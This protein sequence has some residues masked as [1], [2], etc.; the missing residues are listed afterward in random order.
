MSRMSRIRQHERVV[1]LCMALSFALSADYMNLFVRVHAFHVPL[2]LVTVPTVARNCHHNRCSCVGRTST[3]S[4]RQLQWRTTR[5]PSSTISAV[6]PS[7]ITRT[8][9]TRL[10]QTVPPSDDDNL[11]SSSPGNN[12]KNENGHGQHDPRSNDTADVNNAND[13]NNDSSLSSSFTF[14]L[15][16]TT[17]RRSA[18]QNTNTTVVPSYR[19]LLRFISTTILIWLS[20]PLL[21]LVDTTLVGTVTQQSSSSVHVPALIQLA[22]LGPATML[23]DSLVYL[24]YFLSIATTCQ[25]ARLLAKRDYQQMRE[26]TSEILGIS[27][28]LGAGITLLMFSNSSSALLQWC[29]GSAGRSTPLLLQQALQY[30][31]IRC[32][33]SIF[34]IIG[35]QAQSICLAVQDTRTPAIAMAVAS[36][37]NVVGDVLLIPRHGL[38]GAALA[39]AA[40]SVLSTCVLLMSIRSKTQEWKYYAGTGTRTTPINGASVNGASNATTL[41]GPTALPPSTA[42]VDGKPVL[43][44]SNITLN[45]GA[46]RSAAGG[47]KR[48]LSLSLSSSIAALRKGQIPSLM[49]LTASPNNADKN[50]VPFLSLPNKQSAI[51]LIQLAGPLFFIIVAKVLSYS[52]L[53]YK[54]TN[55]GVVSVACHS[56]MMRIFFFYATFG[57]ALTQAAQTYLPSTLL[58]AEATTTTGTTTIAAEATTTTPAQAAATA[59]VGTNEA[60]NDNVNAKR[61]LSKLFVFATGIGLFNFVSIQ[62][63][64]RRMGR[65]FTQN[66]E[67]IAVMTKHSF[68]ISVAAMLHSFIMVYEG[69]LIAKGD[70]MFLVVSYVT[71]MGILVTQLACATPSFAQVWSALLVFQVLRLAQFSVR[72][73]HTLWLRRR[74]QRSDPAELEPKL[75]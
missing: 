10:H 34:T 27:T 50:D 46:R 17:T 21:S 57:D 74:Q 12:K 75:V 66:T 8:C 65:L 47:A 71:I 20:E 31:R 35:I 23:I 36:V 22:A 28:L 26:T 5:T 19:A 38:Q 33:V 40:A 25:M 13:N 72:V 49:L 52:A 61:L 2:S 67:I 3:V 41:F 1:L 30:C 58:A 7:A 39:T 16:N 4:Q 24:T 70:F 43:T 9:N 68:A 42:I 11:D 56:I 62:S 37:V 15:S 29:A 54:A 14:P 44:A 64:L 45:K 73:V 48:V 32:S 60:A 53:T 51:A 6:T 59:A 69:A 63:I 18:N 55:F